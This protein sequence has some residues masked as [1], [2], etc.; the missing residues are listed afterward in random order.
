MNLRHEGFLIRIINSGEIL[1][2]ASP[3]FF[4]KALGITLFRYL[5]STINIQVPS[6]LVSDNINQT[7]SVI[8][9]IKIRVAQRRLVLF[10]GRVRV[11]LDI[12]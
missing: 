8:K 1:D 2:L 5:K 11:F 3:D 4:V 7:R 6:L 9:H 12:G 10:R